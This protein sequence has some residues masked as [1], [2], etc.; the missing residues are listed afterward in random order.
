MIN[1]EGIIAEPVQAEGGDH[2]GSGYWFRGLQTLCRKHDIQLIIDEVQTGGGATGKMWC[3]EHFQL[4]DGADIVTYSKKML[5]AGIY[6]K[7]D[8]APKHPARIFNT[9]VGEPSKLILLEAVLDTI[10]KE[11]LLARVT[12]VGDDMIS[13]LED[14]AS[15][16]P[17][18]FRNV[19]GK[20]YHL[21]LLS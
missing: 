3:H 13:G 6:H 14:L 19:R 10:A 16:Y 5:A 12:E 18:V 20:V 17:G 1:T 15:K 7:K 8:L 11:N 2:H 9:W 4:E 21:F